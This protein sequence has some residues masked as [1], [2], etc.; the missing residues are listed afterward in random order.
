MERNSLIVMLMSATK[1]ILLSLRGP[2]N[3]ASRLGRRRG[4]HLHLVQ[5]VKKVEI[6]CAVNVASILPPL[7]PHLP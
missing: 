3:F 1:R 7:Q 5:R 4:H 6:L 2:D